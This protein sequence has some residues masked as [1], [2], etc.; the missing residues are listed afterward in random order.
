MVFLILCNRA[1][2]VWISAW[3]LQAT[4]CNLCRLKTL[5]FAYRRF[6]QFSANANNGKNNGKKKTKNRERVS[7][8][9]TR[10]FVSE[11][12]RQWGLDLMVSRIPSE[13]FGEGNVPLLFL[14]GGFFSSMATGIRQLGRKIT[15]APRCI[16][17]QHLLLMRYSVKISTACWRF[18][19]IGQFFV[20]G[21]SVKPKS[22]KA[23]W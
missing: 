2:A 12:E 18:C 17:P 4:V 23:V 16:L 11:L 10:R 3:W 9:E 7:L 20:N 6:G 22:M 15:T 21:V 13:R 1:A 8:V 5:R 19:R 14:Y